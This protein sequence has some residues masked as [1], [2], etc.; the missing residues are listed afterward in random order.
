M[1]QASTDVLFGLNR[2]WDLV[3]PGAIL[4]QFVAIFL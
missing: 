2:T 3:G 4:L 1:D